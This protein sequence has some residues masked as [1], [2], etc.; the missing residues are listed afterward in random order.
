LHLAATQQLPFA[1]YDVDTILL[2]EKCNSFRVLVANPAGSLHRCRQVESYVTNCYP[3]LLGIA[4][5]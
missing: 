2:E 1:R 4:P 5:D 3:K